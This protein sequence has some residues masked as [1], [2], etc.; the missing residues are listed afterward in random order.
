MFSAS[1]AL[2]VSRPRFLLLSVALVASA[3]AA[4]RCA[5][6]WS[7]AYALLA[8]VGL[9]ALHAAVDAINEA[10]DA[11]SGIDDHTLR[12]PFSG[13]T[14]TIQAGA[15]SARGAYLWGF[16]C[17]A[18]GA[19]IGVWFLIEVGVALLPIL[20]LGAVS[21][22]AYTHVFLRIGL[23]ELFAGLGL[24]ALPI[25]GASMIHS[26]SVPIQGVAVAIPAFFMTFNLLFLAEFPDAEAD[27][28]GG[29]R[30]LVIL[31]GRRRAALLYVAVALA[32]PISIAAAVALGWLPPLCLLACL[33]TL[34]L[35]PGFRWA[36]LDAD[37]P[38]PL[39]AL[40]SNVIWNLG[41]HTVL[42]ATLAWA[43]S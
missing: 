13:G 17:T 30:H 29:R 31:L 33:P 42:A 22:L 1:G 9:V 2:G 5:G 25:L 8:L 11:I 28:A 16:F 39:P 12:T 6:F 14:G 37:N 18:V 40:A 20:V 36:L 24:G 23:G 7:P 35:A 4:A 26:G 21:V 32:A 41:T 34:L 43:C 19:S 10:G 27:R 38:T 15:I 3:T